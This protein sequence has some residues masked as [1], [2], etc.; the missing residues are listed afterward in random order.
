MCLPPPPSAVGV[1]DSVAFQ[2]V[3]QDEGLPALGAAVGPLAAVGAL[4]DPQAALLREPL[5]ALPAAEWLLA[6][7]RPV[8]YAEVGRAL[9]ALPAH[10]APERPLP[11]VALLVQLELVQAAERLPALQA[12][13]APRRRGE[14]LVGVVVAARRERAVG[15]GHDRA[16]SGCGVPLGVLV[17]RPQVRRVPLRV[18][19]L[20][21]PVRLRERARSS[22]LKPGRLRDVLLVLGAVDPVA[23]PLRGRLAAVGNHSSLRVLRERAGVLLHHTGEVGKPSVNV[24]S[25]D[26]GRPELILS[27]VD[28]K[29]RGELILLPGAVLTSVLT[30]SRKLLLLLR[31]HSEVKAADLS[32]VMTRVVQV[33]EIGRF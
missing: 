8:V 32:C 6:R 19:L 18:R 9:E 12:D 4:V 21:L 11:L 13:V 30:E 25:L 7:V 16:L 14:R 2:M 3:H 33:T 1:N 15:V 26:Y 17:R 29:V 20:L 5:P 24:V 27:F 28:G 22:G 23:R 10:G 31:L